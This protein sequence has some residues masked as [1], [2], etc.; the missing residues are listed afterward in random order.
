MMSFSI[1]V[2]AARLATPPFSYEYVALRVR[3]KWRIRDSRDDAVGSAQTEE[4]AKAAVLF[5]I[6]A[7]V[8]PTPCPTPAQAAPQ[9]TA[10]AV[11]REAIEGLIRH[12]IGSVWTLTPLVD[13]IMETLNSPLPQPPEDQ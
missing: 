5:L 13:A 12:H 11:T 10:G 1:N 7:Q 4:D 3:D 2:E 6:R 9:Q 8:Q